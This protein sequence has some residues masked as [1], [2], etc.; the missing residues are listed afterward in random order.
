MQ[1]LYAIS[2]RLCG[3]EKRTLKFELFTSYDS[4]L[5]KT[6]YEEEEP[7]VANAHLRI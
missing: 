5:R 3:K 4:I 1:Q 2:Y 7:T 6:Y